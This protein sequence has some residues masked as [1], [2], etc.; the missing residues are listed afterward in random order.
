MNLTKAIKKQIKNIIDDTAVIWIPLW[1]IFWGVIFVGALFL[2][3][4][5][6]KFFWYL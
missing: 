5:L 3:I 1:F 4:K 2:I 6:I